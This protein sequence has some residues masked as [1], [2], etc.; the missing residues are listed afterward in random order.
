[1]QTRLSVEPAW[2][3]AGGRAVVDGRDRS[4]HQ[5]TQLPADDVPGPGGVAQGI[6]DFLGGRGKKLRL[7]R[8]QQGRQAALARNPVFHGQ[9]H[10]RPCRSSARL[11]RL[12]AVSYSMAVRP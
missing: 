10:A 9:D 12:R 1:M 2:Q 4:A 5:R 8:V 7:Q 11:I 6:A 3:A